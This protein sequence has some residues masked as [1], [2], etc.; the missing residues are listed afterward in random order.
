MAFITVGPHFV[1]LDKMCGIQ[2]KRTSHPDITMV[3]I[4]YEHESFEVG[5]EGDITEVTETIYNALNRS[6]H[7]YAGPEEISEQ[8]VGVIWTSDK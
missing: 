8:R 2:V 7:I 6:Y 5:C 3:I 1:N 4:H